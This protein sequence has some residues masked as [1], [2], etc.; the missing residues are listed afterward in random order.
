V[1]CFIYFF[2]F[3]LV[4]FDDT[5]GA[6]VTAAVKYNWKTR[7]TSV[8]CEW[9]FGSIQVFNFL[10]ALYYLLYSFL[11]FYSLY[12]TIILGPI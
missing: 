2:D 3:A 1:F 11:F 5:R 9:D 12:F 7:R 4:V 10:F 6:E 8:Q